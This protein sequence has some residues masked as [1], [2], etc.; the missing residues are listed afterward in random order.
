M[1]LVIDQRWEQNIAVIDLKGPMTLG[2]SLNAL[3]VG[4]RKLLESPLI[5][6]II[7]DVGGVTF[8]DSAGLGE[9]TLIYTFASRRSCPVILTGVSPSLKHSLEI[10]RLDALLPSAPDLESARKRLADMK[11]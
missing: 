10:T 11:T 5:L 7:L 3:S 4:A 2:P 6:G 9:L 1:P 8:V